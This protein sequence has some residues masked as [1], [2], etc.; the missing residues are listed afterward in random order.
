MAKIIVLGAGGWGTAIAIMCT[1]Y[2]HEVCLWSRSAKDV[3]ALRRDNE[4]KRLLPGVTLPDGLKL[5]ADIGETGRADIVVMAVPS[6]AVRETAR[7]LTGILPEGVI[8]VNA[9]KGLEEESLKRLT[10]VLGEELP[11]TRTAVLSGPSHAEEVSRGIPTAAVSASAWPDAAAQVQDIFMNPDFRI[12]V[13]PDVVGVELG[14]ALKNVIALAAGICDGLGLGDN[15]KAALMTRGISEM[16]RLGVAMGGRAQTF[17][18]LTGIGDLIVTCTSEHSRNHRAGVYIGRGLTPEQAVDK[19][20]MT[21]EGYRTA[22]AAYNLSVRMGVE[23]PI[24]SECYRMLYEGTDPGTAI[25]RLMQREK[26]HEIED[27]WLTGSNIG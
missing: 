13:N 20:G 18:G 2:G 7:K 6:S 5:T 26:K 25:R 27:I 12:Y 4:N 22:R 23:M 3:D 8:V 9:A 24:V 1:R 21:V 11:G 17:A 14:G 16:A 19:V 10:Q 15:T